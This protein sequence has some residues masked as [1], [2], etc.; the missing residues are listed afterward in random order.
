M[1]YC[2]RLSANLKCCQS[3][4][5]S[6]QIHPIDK[7]LRENRFKIKINPMNDKHNSKFKL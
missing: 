1:C 3:N 7:I 2:N 5:K 6:K 4:S